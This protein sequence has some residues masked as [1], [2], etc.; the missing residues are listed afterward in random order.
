M[1]WLD[2]A[3]AVGTLGLLLLLHQRRSRF[4]R[5]GF[6]IGL[7]I[8][9]LMAW[10]VQ[11]SQPDAW[12]FD[13]FY[14][15]IQAALLIDYL[16]EK[17]VP[18]RAAVLVTTFA[19]GFLALLESSGLLLFLGVNPHGSLMAWH[20]VF[21]LVTAA[22]LV[23]FD[24]LLK[25][26]GLTRINI[27]FVL[28]G[29]A[30]WVWWRFLERPYSLESHLILAAVALVMMAFYLEQSNPRQTIPA[31][32]MVAYQSLLGTLERLANTT[33]NGTNFSD[34]LL[35]TMFGTARLMVGGNSDQELWG[36]LL[37]A[38]VLL[39]PGAEAGSL[40]LRIGTNFRYVAQ[41]GH[42]ST[43]IGVE[44][45]EQNAREWHG[46][47]MGWHRGDPRIV[48][49]PQIF[50]GQNPILQQQIFA[51]K[52]L[53]A[54]LYLPIVVGN[55]V[56]ADLNL[57]NFSNE[58]A[59]NQDS[60][61]GARQFAVQ[62][63]ALMSA[64]RERSDL[65]ARSRE[66][67]SLEAVAEA[68]HDARTPARI[69]ESVLEQAVML[70]NVPHS[71]FLLVASDNSHLKIL[72]A[73]GLFQIMVSGAV[74]RGQGLSWAALEARG[75]VYSS[76]A[77]Q[78]PRAFDPTP[79]DDS[80]PHSQLTVPILDSHGA[81][82]GVLL[83]ARNLPEQF[84][85][86]DQRLT[87]V[88]AKVAGSA[89]ERIRATESLER[90][91]FES[92]NLLNLARLLEGNDAASLE[93]ALERV[94][95]L[96]VAD[97][98]V[99]L[100]IENGFFILQSEVGKNP[101]PQTIARSL[102]LEPLLAWARQPVQRTL[103]LSIDTVGTGMREIG[104]RSMLATMLDG[105]GTLLGAL[106]VY[107]FEQQGWTRSEK[108]LIEAAGGMIGALL[109]RLERLETLEAAYEGALAMIGKS[110]EMRD[111]ETGN[112][113]ERVAHLAVRMAKALQLPDSELRAVRWGAYLHDVG[114]FAIS[115]EV[116]RKPAKLNAEERRLIE[117]H[118][119]NGFELIKD[120]PFLPIT[121]KHIVLY[122]HERWDGMGYPSRL[123]TENI[124]LAARIFAVCDVFDALQSK[125][126]YKAAFSIERTIAEL[127]ASAHSGHLELRLVRLLEQILKE[128][129]TTLRTQ[130][131]LFKL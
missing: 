47:V 37:D 41:Q 23:G 28:V 82:L 43:L 50:L 123:A 60:I 61:R 7:V 90:Q 31:S 94:R 24:L 70:L 118:P 77:M 129:G 97:A 27:L 30:G 33:R 20:G 3:T 2:L 36:R 125:R 113:T 53:R 52:K 17:T 103:E 66:F 91:I 18:W 49:Q 4:G 88:I 105:G 126:S 117:Q 85:N 56:V 83:V 57:D 9:V 71:A 11:I 98:V 40:R 38:A 124:P 89:L 92:R 112:H 93:S 12:L 68:L 65:E 108:P 25:R 22:V 15:V 120:I 106:V 114:K 35:T 26:W 131:E 74:P 46:D 78:D 64:Q 101:N 58:N 10:T 63:A 99:L 14:V 122:H 39:V 127:Y 32:Q 102:Q 107:R 48:R 109:S 5:L 16:L 76:S 86:L 67:T 29:A 45:N 54:N 1:N 51:T 34:N 13:A 42:N 59:F 104:V 128:D 81:P 95:Q 55:E 73:R 121:T 96:A 79:N 130:S 69:A 115:D 19:T 62:L 84:T 44:L 116:L 80:P 100:R 111:L 110:L 87:E 75:T 21:M 8:A 6:L 119:Q 72:S